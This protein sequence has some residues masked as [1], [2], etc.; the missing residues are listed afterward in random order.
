MYRVYAYLLIMLLK[1]LRLI[2][3]FGHAFWILWI[4]FPKLDKEQKTPRDQDVVE[5]NTHGHWNSSR[6]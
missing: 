6:S 5:K 2:Q 1:Y 4:K 3:A